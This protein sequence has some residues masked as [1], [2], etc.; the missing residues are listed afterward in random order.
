MARFEPHRDGDR[1]ARGARGRRVERG[2]QRAPRPRHR[3][4][5]RA[6]AAAAARHRLRA[7]P[8][9]RDGASYTQD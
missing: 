7:R 4:A 9:H 6:R 8:R 1:A 5:P 3:H 2:R